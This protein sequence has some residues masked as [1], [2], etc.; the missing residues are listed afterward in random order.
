MLQCSNY[1]HT[2][3]QTEQLKSIVCVPT[4]EGSAFFFALL[5]R[6]VTGLAAAH[7]IRRGAPGMRAER[8]AHRARSPGHQWDHRWATQTVLTATQNSILESL[9]PHQPLCIL[10]NQSWKTTTM[11]TTG[12][13][14]ICIKHTELHSKPKGV[15]SAIV[16]L[17]PTR[18]LGLKELQRLT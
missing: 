15:S 3:T 6:K 10:E 17:L 4:G 2:H 13:T 12:I 5:S 14:Q 7:S 18:Q 11:A 1:A 9:I 8:A 16:H